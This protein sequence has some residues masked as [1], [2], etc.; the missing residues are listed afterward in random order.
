LTSPS[1]DSRPLTASQRAGPSGSERSVAPA[2]TEGATFTTPEDGEAR[3][4][5]SFARFLRHFSVGF[6]FVTNDLEGYRNG[7]L[8]THLVNLKK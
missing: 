6:K 8:N 3:Y 1:T 7:S 4:H 5:L 2:P